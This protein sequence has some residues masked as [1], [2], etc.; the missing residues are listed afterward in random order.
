MAKLGIG[1]RP[2]RK[3]KANTESE[4]D[5]PIAKNALNRDFTTTEPDRA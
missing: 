1:A 3:F 5:S 2:K 4:H